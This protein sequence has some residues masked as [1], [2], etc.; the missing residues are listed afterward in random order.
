MLKM[1]LGYIVKSVLRDFKLFS[2]FKRSFMRKEIINKTEKTFKA[3]SS[4]YIASACDKWL[5]NRK[6]K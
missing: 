5:F 4:F 1:L 3:C 2:I 6:T